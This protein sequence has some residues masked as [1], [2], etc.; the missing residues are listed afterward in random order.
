MN[1]I[2]NKILIDG[3]IK[4]YPYDEYLMNVG[5]F[6]IISNTSRV[7]E[8]VYQITLFLNDNPYTHKLVS[9][10]DLIYQ[11]DCNFE[12]LKKDFKSSICDEMVYELADIEEKPNEEENKR[13]EEIQLLVVKYENYLSNI[14][15]EQFNNINKVFDFYI[16]NSKE[17]IKNVELYLKQF[18]HL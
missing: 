12:M 11:L 17:C 6:L 4:I 3:A 14:N 1:S 13:V 10:N 8:N 5:F 2:L 7:K 15:E 18:F 16:K 9:A